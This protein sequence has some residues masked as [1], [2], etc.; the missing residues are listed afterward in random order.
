MFFIS[1]EESL[2]QSKKERKEEEQKSS[3]NVDESGN[4]RQSKSRKKEQEQVKLTIKLNMLNT[5]TETLVDKELTKKAVCRKMK[6]IS[7]PKKGDIEK[8]KVTRANHIQH[9][10]S[11]TRD[12]QIKHLS[13][14]NKESLSVKILLKP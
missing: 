4:V 11:G 12:Y 6:V 14:V 8:T 1:F 3:E 2:R 9:L 13:R 10:G 5:L 7:A